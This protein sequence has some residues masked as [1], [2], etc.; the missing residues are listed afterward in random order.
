MRLIFLS[1]IFSILFI[2]AKGQVTSYHSSVLN[3]ERCLI[4]NKLD[5]SLYYYNLSFNKLKNPFSR[6]LYNASVVAVKTGKNKLANKFLTRIIELGA[7]VNILSENKVLEKYFKNDGKI[8]YQNAHNIR[9]T[10]NTKFRTEIKQM[11]ERDQY[12]RLKRN[13]NKAY[14][15]SIKVADAQNIKSLLNFINKNGFPTES[16]IGIDSK[17]YEVAYISVI[18]FHQGNGAEQQYNFSD[19][20]IDNVKKGTLDNRLGNDLFNRNSGFYSFDY[21]RFELVKVI[22]STK[23]ATRRNNYV[24]ID[25]SK[26]GFMPYS[27]K[28]IQKIDQSRKAFF[29]DD[30]KT[31]LQKILF[32][33]DKQ[34]YLLGSIYSGTSLIYTDKN[35]FD[36]DKAKLITN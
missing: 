23:P 33:R 24:L 5:S 8:F 7:E 26:W 12:Y 15:D 29:L 27:E 4:S 25:S 34:E 19:I 1:S 10:Y 30:Y 6:D 11:F 14:I 9:P 35:A 2:T 32:N 17:A 28:E 36:A 22:D 20:I 3:A 13:G 21:M 16:L 31:H 18:L